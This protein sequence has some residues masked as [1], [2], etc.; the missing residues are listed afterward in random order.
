MFTTLLNAKI[1]EKYL[2]GANENKL[3]IPGYEASEPKEAPTELVKII[4]TRE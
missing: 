2:S 4:G 1:F 3:R